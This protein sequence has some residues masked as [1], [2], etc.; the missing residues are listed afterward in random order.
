MFEL[1][2]IHVPLFCTGSEGV[3]LSDLRKVRLDSHESVMKNALVR[4]FIPYH[5]LSI[6][7]VPS[8]EDGET[9]AVV[10]DCTTSDIYQVS[11]GIPMSRL[12]YALEMFK[13]IPSYDPSWI[14]CYLD[15]DHNS[16]PLPIRAAVYVRECPSGCF[17][18]KYRSVSDVRYFDNDPVY[19]V[20][21]RD[22]RFVDTWEALDRVYYRFEYKPEMESYRMLILSESI[23]SEKRKLATAI[24]RG[25]DL[26]NLA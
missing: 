14:L 8:Q 4:A 2:R 3:V 24:Q 25:F 19:S 1:D 13:N 26:E 11:P 7:I 17:H 21:A 9:T 12:Q 23:T 16:I 20:S 18:L 6:S 5:F 22:W 15:G 10:G